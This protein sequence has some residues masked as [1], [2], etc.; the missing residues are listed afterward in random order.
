V[1][2]RRH[3]R[4]KPTRPK[5]NTA[6]RLTPTPMPILAPWESPLGDDDVTGTGETGDDDVT[7]TG[8]TGDED[9]TGT[10]ETGDEDPGDGDEDPGDGPGVGV[11]GI[12]WLLDDVTVAMAVDVTVVVV[13]APSTMVDVTVDCTAVLL[14]EV[15]TLRTV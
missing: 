11:V 14:V 13:L 3:H 5:T 9:V 6:A 4:Q 7:G 15:T 1:L 12:T 10:G 2:R 8:E